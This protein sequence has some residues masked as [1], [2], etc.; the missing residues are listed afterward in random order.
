MAASIN[1]ANIPPELLKQLG[2]RKPRTTQFSKE[3]VRKHA[4]RALATIAELSQEQRRRV[5]EHASRIN[6]L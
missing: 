2:L 1:A 3:H 5:L 4:L 6:K